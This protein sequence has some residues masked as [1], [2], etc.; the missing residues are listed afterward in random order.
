MALLTAGHNTLNEGNVANGSCTQAHR[1]S[2]KSEW[3]VSHDLH[4]THCGR[5]RQCTLVLATF[6]SRRPL[7]LSAAG[8][9][10]VKD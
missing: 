7:Q 5:M 3:N 2:V 10:T 1:S 4:R 9:S 6:P 8:F